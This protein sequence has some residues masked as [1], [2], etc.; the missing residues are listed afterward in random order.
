MTF[1][2]VHFFLSGALTRMPLVPSLWCHCFAKI[3]TEKL[4]IVSCRSCKKNWLEMIEN[5][6]QVSL[7]TRGASAVVAT[8]M[9]AY[10]FSDVLF[11]F[12]EM[13]G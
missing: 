7:S 10:S 5:S 3:A 9:E 4:D 2:T 13:P 8:S 1:V 12:K 6:I 11:L